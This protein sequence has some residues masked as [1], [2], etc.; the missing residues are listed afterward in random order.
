M[1]KDVVT[2][3]DRDTGNRTND[4]AENDD[5]VRRAQLER[6]SI[7]VGKVSRIEVEDKKMEPK[8]CN[9][10]NRGFCKGDLIVTFYTIMRFVRDM[11][12]LAS[13]TSKGA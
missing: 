13:L 10:Y 7:L 4:D 8:K 12:S 3:L 1:A 5:T 6:I 2:M 11:K 9:F